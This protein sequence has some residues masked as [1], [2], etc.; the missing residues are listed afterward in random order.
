MKIGK[1]ISLSLSLAIAAV[2]AFPSAGNAVT[3]STG[4]Y[5]GKNLQKVEVV[6]YANAKP[7]A[8]TTK[9]GG[10]YKLTGYKLGLGGSCYL[11]TSGVDEGAVSKFQAAVDTW[12]AATSAEV[13]GSVTSDSDAV[14]GDLDGKNSIVFDRYPTDGVIA[15][16]AYWVDRSTR[17]VV[18]FD[19]MYNTYYQWGT[20]E[21]NG[22]GV[23][24]IQNIATHEFGHAFGLSDIYSSAYSHVTMYGYSNFGDIAKRTLDP[25]DVLGIQKIYGK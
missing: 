2:F 12:D 14:Y 3:L 18:E 19:M 1:N 21:S 16:T 15:V 20:V 23:M 11:N 9:T 5:P 25:Q 4:P 10:G 7:G 17:T 24:D 8:A 22:T 6:H 13:F